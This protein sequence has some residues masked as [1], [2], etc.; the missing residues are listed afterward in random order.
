VLKEDDERAL[1]P[2]KDGKVD[3]NDLVKR[4]VE[5]SPGGSSSTFAEKFLANLN[6]N[7]NADCPICF[8][9]MEVPMVIPKCMHQL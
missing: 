9:E 8:N 3:V 7:N 4:F 5:S 2:E 1:F 6:D